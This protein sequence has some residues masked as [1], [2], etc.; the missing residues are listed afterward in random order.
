M[1]RAAGEGFRAL[2]SQ[3]VA[4]QSRALKMIFTI[5]PRVIAIWYWQGQLRGTLG[6]V[7]LAPHSGMTKNTELP[8][9]YRD[10]QK[11]VA[12]MAPTPHLDKLPALAQL[13]CLAT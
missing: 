6:T 1:I 5:V 3:G 10:V 4:V 2:A 12:G 11:M 13:S 9:L 8:I 7:A